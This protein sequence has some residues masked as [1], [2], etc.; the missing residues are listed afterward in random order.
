MT[1]D[2]GKTLSGVP[3]TMLRF[4]V[5]S[6]LSEIGLCRYEIRL[7]F[8]SDSTIKIYSKVMVFATGDKVS[9]LME[10]E[11]P[12]T[13]V[14]LS[15]LLQDVVIDLTSEEPDRFVVAFDSGGKIEILLDDQSPESFLVNGPDG[16]LFVFGLGTATTY[17]GSNGV[18][19]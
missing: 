11:G 15:A 16:S 8:D 17:P 3:L 1:R 18:K 19:S 6:R 12:K 10:G 7:Y 2:R 13:D 4:L 9:H 5:G 14:P